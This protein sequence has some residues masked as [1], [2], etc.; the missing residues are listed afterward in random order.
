MLYNG[1][2]AL[3]LEDEALG[4]VLLLQV[5]PVLRTDVTNFNAELTAHP[6]QMK[7]ERRRRLIAVIN[8]MLKK[9]AASTSPSAVPATSFRCLDSVS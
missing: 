5:H 1:V 6:T 7:I 8:N 3:D 4:K 9:S 2:V